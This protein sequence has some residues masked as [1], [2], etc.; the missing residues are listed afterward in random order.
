[1]RNV[2]ETI[3]NVTTIAIAVR[4]DRAVAAGMDTVRSFAPHYPRLHAGPTL[5]HW[6]A[7]IGKRSKQPK[8]GEGLGQRGTSCLSESRLSGSGRLWSGSIRVI[9]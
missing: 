2:I 6:S 8:Q 3:A 9:S 7:P 5:K 1:M 4:T